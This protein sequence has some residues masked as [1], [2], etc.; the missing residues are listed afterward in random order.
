MKTMIF[1]TAAL[2]LAGTANAATFTS[3]AGNPDPM[4]AAG[5]SILYDFEGAGGGAGGAALSGSFSILP[6]SVDG[7][8]APAG[9]ATQF[10][11]VPVAGPGSPTNGSATLSLAGLPR[12]IKTFS[13]YWGS[14]DQYNTLDLFSGGNLVLSLNGTMLPPANGDQGSGITNRR[15][16]F[17][18]SKDNIDSLTFTSQGKAFEFDDLAVSYV[19][20]PSSWAMLI[21]GFGFIGVAARKRRSVSTVAA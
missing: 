18:V 20:E 6:G 13:F 8:A 9:D 11:A 17:N 10:V 2:L 16:F 5:E 3:V 15:V 14:I 12:A 21:A 4:A 1:A 19:P 7:A